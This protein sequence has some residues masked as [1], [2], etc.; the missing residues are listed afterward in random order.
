MWH[1]KVQSALLLQRLCEE[2]CTHC[3]G[4]CAGMVLSCMCP[5]CLLT[6]SASSSK[7]LEPLRFF[8]FLPFSSPLLRFFE[9]V[10]FFFEAF[11]CCS[12]SSSSSSSSSPAWQSMHGH[13]A[14]LD[15][16]L[17]RT[18][19]S[20][21]PD[22]PDVSICGLQCVTCK[23]RVFILIIIYILL[24]FTPSHAAPLHLDSL[25]SELLL[26]CG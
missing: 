1:G 3:M 24:L 25:A 4:C 11:C 16:M 8:F 21:R 18:V 7:K 20:T 23:V 15:C 22:C 13:G 14:V 2:G 6:S 12:G 9:G 19:S 17:C 5:A 10:F 26:C